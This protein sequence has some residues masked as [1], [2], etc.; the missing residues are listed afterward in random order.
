MMRALVETDI[1]ILKDIHARFYSEQFD[2]PDFLHHFLHPFVICSDNGNIITA[3]GIVP[4][5]EVIILTDKSYSVRA[6]QT[7]LKDMLGITRFLAAKIGYTRLHAF[8]QDPIWKTHLLDTGFTASKGD[9]LNI[10]V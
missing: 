4:I 7:A 3:G 1:P 5:A 8:V 9:C 2:F 10:G 6:R